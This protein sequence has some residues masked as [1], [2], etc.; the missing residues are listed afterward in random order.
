VLQS[1]F[2]RP[3][4]SFRLLGIPV[5]VELT[6]LIT[7]FLLA[8]GERA[9]MAS[10][11]A[12]LGVVFVSVLS[13]EL[14]HA[15]VG[16]RFGLTPAVRLYGW[17]GLTSWTAGPAPGPARRL[18]ISVAGPFVNIA[19]GA[20]CQVALD[21]T[22]AAAPAV[23][24]VLHD[25]VW[26]AGFWGLVNLAPLLPLDGGHACEALLARFAPAHEAQGARLVSAVTGFALGAVALDR[27][28]LLGG[29]AA[30]W[31]GAES[32]RAWLGER[33]RR[34]DTTLQARLGPAFTAAIDARDGEA[35]VSLATEALPAARTDETRSWLAEHLAI[36]HALRGAFPDA[37]AALAA[38]PIAPPPS[39]RIEAFVVMLAVR[40][41]KRDL[42]IAAGA[43]P[44]AWEHA[45]SPADGEA[46]ERA[47]QRLRGAHEGSLDAVAFARAREAAEVLAHAPEAARLGEALFEQAPDPDLAF[48]VACAWASAGDAARAG[49]YAGRAVDLGFRDWERAAE[50]EALAGNGGDRARRVLEEAMTRGERPRDAGTP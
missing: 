9:S 8:G 20:A 47:C 17:G 48:A 45:G 4:F 15:I 21:V 29:A 22:P 38:A 43:D 33:R 46:W 36:G 12:W 26:A 24:L 37:A 30:F 2:S 14:G 49:D 25:F 23:R 42:A 41:R 44:D 19:L 7:T 34:A 50:V 39:V 5:A 18:G 3:L 27:G 35:M 13:H 1:S 32:G 40:H 31:L 11:G 16:R 6:F 10:F 28:F